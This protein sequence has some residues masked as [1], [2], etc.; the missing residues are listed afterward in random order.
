MRAAEERIAA[1]H[2]LANTPCGT[3]EYGEQGRGRPVLVLHGAGGGYDQGLL[4]A[5][6]LRGDFRVIAPSRF[7]Y[8]GTPIPED[9][10]LA[11]QAMAYAC[12]LDAL[13]IDRVA[14]VAGSAGG[15][16]ALQ[17]ALRY[18]DRVDAL[19]LVS[20][21]STLRPIREETGGPSSAQL[22]DFAYW[23]AVTFQPN[24]VLKVLGI[25][26]E[27]LR[28]LSK[29][30]YDRMLVAL[31]TMQPMSRRLPGMNHDA[32]EQG[33]PEAAALPIE[34][35]TAPTLVVHATDDALIPF[36]QGRHSADHIPGARLLSVE[37]GGHFAF[38]LDAPAAEIRAF[39]VSESR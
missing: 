6:A 37:H 23:L 21:I 28:H 10:S 2:R 8:L 36:A 39:L 11:A 16:S 13:K 29:T 20:A 19:V 38:V 24:A 30:E 9:G 14:V 17:F 27:S 18:P 33:K 5:H 3:I 31:R 26:G 34:K 22:S 12:L 7:G 32:I 35:I 15:P 4:V 1:G 25:P